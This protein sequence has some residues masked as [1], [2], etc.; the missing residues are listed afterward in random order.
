MNETIRNL[1]K[2]YHIPAYQIGDRLGISENTVYR[3]LRHELSAEKEKLFYDAIRSL[4]AEKRAA[5]DRQ[6]AD[7][8]N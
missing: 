3:W 6:I 2:A 7:L 8:K 4:A 5:L 1:A